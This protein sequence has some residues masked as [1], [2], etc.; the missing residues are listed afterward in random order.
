[1]FMSHDEMYRTRRLFMVNETLMELLVVVMF[2]FGKLPSS[3]LHCFASVYS[4]LCPIVACVI[5]AC[6][7]LLAFS[8]FIHSSL[9]TVNC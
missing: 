7:V 9:M 1:M 3:V 5:S 6:L 2:C 8:F 4:V